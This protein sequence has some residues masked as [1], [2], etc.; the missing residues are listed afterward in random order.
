MN[1]LALAPHPEAVGEYLALFQQFGRSTKALGWPDPQQHQQR[2]FALTSHILPG[3][4]VLDFGCGQGHL[5]EH[6]DTRRCSVIY[7]GVD[8]LP[9]FIAHCGDHFK[10]RDEP[11]LFMRID[12]PADIPMRDVGFDHVVSC[13]VFNYRGSWP[14]KRH[15]EHITANLAALWGMT[16]TALHV[17]FLAPDVD[18]R[19]PHLHYQSTH[20]LINWLKDLGCRRWVIDRSYLPNEFC[21]HFYK[22][23]ERIA[24]GRMWARPVMP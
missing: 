8:V 2:L 9:E 17:D 12:D 10:D 23:E 6:F 24:G 15:E 3:E 19:E 11:A 22:D 4:T 16:K 21:I 18:Y 1:N 13:G 20:T 7:T 5:L 14:L